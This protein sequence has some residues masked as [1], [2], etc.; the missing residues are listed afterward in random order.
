MQERGEVQRRL[1]ALAVQQGCGCAMLGVGVVLG[2][3]ALM[4]LVISDW[5]L[6]G[7]K[8]AG[9]SL[10]AV[11]IGLLVGG[12][13]AVVVGIVWWGWSARTHARVLRAVTPEEWRS[14]HWPWDDPTLLIDRSNLQVSFVTGGGCVNC[15]E[16]WE[17]NRRKTVELSAGAKSA[18]KVGAFTSIVGP[19]AHGT[20]VTDR[21][22]RLQEAP[23]CA[24]GV[25]VHYALC[26]RCTPSPWWFAVA[27]IF[28]F[29]VGGQRVAF[30]LLL[31]GEPEDFSPALEL[32]EL[33]L[34]WPV[35]GA[36]LAAW[37]V[38]RQA[39][40]EIAVH[41]ADDGVTIMLPPHLTVGPGLPLK[42]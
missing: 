6:S 39:G 3:C 13:A 22:G 42:K 12:V 26:E 27:G 11:V 23:W 24:R 30:R 17:P 40:H 10:Q 16:P 18:L 2:F 8:L 38:G 19:V 35:G 33:F 25:T 36:L 34:P 37:A 9:L 1:R 7:P 41:T 28:A 32:L 14:E 31:P 5:K 15:G 20:P 4:A 29:V 21:V